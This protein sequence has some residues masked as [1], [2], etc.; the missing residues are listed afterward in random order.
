MEKY[1]DKDYIYGS[2]LVTFNDSKYL[3]ILLSCNSN[4]KD[5]IA[6]TNSV[7]DDEEVVKLNTA[8]RSV[9]KINNIS[10]KQKKYKVSSINRKIV[11]LRNFYQFYHRFIDSHFHNL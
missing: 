3:K 6:F 7:G 8:K 9:V 11:S 4:T 5:V 2:G 1:N 10:L